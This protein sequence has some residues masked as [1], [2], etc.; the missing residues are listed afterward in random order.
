MTN[1]QPDDG[2]RV[3]ESDDQVRF[4]EPDGTT[5]VTINLAQKD[6]DRPYRIQHWRSSQEIKDADGKIVA[7]TYDPEYA[8]HICKLLIASFRW[9]KRKAG[10]IPQAEDAANRSS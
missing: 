3:V 2:L 10:Q 6:D 4:I 1:Q 9:E 8:E 5:S 7:R